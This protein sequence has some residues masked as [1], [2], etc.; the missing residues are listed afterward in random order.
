MYGGARK[1]VKKPVKE[2]LV[3]IILSKRNARGNKISHQP[4]ISST[5][6]GKTAKKVNMLGKHSFKKKR[7]FMKNY[8]LFRTAYVF[9]NTVKV[10]NKDFIKAVRGGGGTVL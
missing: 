5:T 9:R 6:L 8:L 4:T 2:R 3:R 1:A 7:K 10:L